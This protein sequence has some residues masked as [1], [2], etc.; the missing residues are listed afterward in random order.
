MDSY[1]IHA[2]DQVTAKR[3]RIL[4]DAGRPPRVSVDVEGGAPLRC[5]LSFSAPGEQIALAAYEP[6]RGWAEDTGADPGP[7]AE[8][9]PVFIHAGDCPGWDGSAPYPRA[10]RRVFRAYDGH[11]NILGGRLAERGESHPDVLAEMFG[12]PDVALVHMRALE[13]GCFFY[14]ARRV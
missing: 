9:G 2:I 12:D 11:G 1:T 14:E 7:Y 8:R 5:C 6:L 4:D 3:L 10:A 13:F